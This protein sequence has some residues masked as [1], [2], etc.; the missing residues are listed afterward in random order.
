MKMLLNFGWLTHLSH[1]CLIAACVTTAM[2]MSFLVDVCLVPII[3]SLR[4]GVRSVYKIYIST[5]KY[6]H[7]VF[8]QCQKHKE[9]IICIHFRLFGTIAP[10]THTRIFVRTKHVKTDI[11]F[12]CYDNRYKWHWIYFGI[13]LKLIKTQRW[14]RKFSR[15]CLE[16][17][18]SGGK[19]P[20][21]RR[22]HQ[23]KKTCKLAECE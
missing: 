1:C 19:K 7:D 17:S 16:N 22:C 15:A 3:F 8:L 5:C 6:R 9:N 12:A 20:Y 4:F 13:L 2:S 14:H 18:T 11:K 10:N 23:T 21:F